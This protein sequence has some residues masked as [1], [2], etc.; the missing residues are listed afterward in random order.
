[1]G[2]DD[3]GLNVERRVQM[4][5]ATLCDP[6]LP[7]DPEFTPPQP[8]AKGKLPK[9]PVRI[10]RPNF[11]ELCEQ[12]VKEMEDEYHE[13]WATIGLSVAWAPT[14]TTLGPTATRISPKAVLIL[15]KRDLAYR[16][17]ETQLWH[18]DTNR[19]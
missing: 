15:S 19:R 3:N 10:S 11:V 9:D 7:Y 13:L 6:T 5:T 14:Y 16:A 18:D 2:W 12:V 4:L 8:D 1:M 17:R